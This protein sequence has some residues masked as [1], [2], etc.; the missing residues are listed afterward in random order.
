MPARIFQKIWFVLGLLMYIG[1]SVL[2]GLA[3]ALDMHSSTRLLA[4]SPLALVII[5]PLYLWVSWRWRTRIVI[6]DFLVLFVPF[7]AL[8]IM[9]YYVMSPRKG[10]S[11]ALIEIG[12][13]GVS[14]CIYALRYLLYKK[15]RVVGLAICFLCIQI[16]ISCAIAYCVPVL[17]D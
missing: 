11:N 6:V 9:D 10:L 14:L 13:V 8:F 17:P 3:G 5:A 2:A 16:L 1:Y 15:N 4:L 12:L 7:L